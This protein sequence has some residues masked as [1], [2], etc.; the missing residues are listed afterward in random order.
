MSVSAPPFDLCVARGERYSFRD[1][2]G[3]L[4]IPQKKEPAHYHVDIWAVAT[5]FVFYSIVVPP[6]VG[7]VHEEFLCLVWTLLY[8]CKASNVG[9]M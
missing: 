4:S 7:Q 6:H 9:S 3:I 1:A 2:T 8:F 5:D